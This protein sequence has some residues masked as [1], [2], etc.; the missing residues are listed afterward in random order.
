MKVAD[1]SKRTGVEAVYSGNSAELLK[2]FAASR[3]SYVLAQS[4]K[5]RKDFERRNSPG[6]DEATVNE[7]ALSELEAD[8]SS[9]DAR[10]EMIPGKEAFSFINTHLQKT[11]GV[12][13]TS[14]GVIDAMT[15][16]EI[17]LEM[18]NLV[19]ALEEFSSVQSA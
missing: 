4:L 16:D 18:Q 8:W 17:P 2:E 15:A 3:K 11:H 1:Q 9:E 13:I 19:T 5:S 6:V 14:Y 12:S 10:F 7:R